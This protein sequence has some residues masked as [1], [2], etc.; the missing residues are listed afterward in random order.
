MDFYKRCSIILQRCWEFKGSYHGVRW[1]IFQ[2]LKLL[3]KY[4][5]TFSAEKMSCHKLV[6]HCTLNFR[7][8]FLTTVHYTSKHS[9]LNELLKIWW[10]L[11]DVK[12]KLML[13]GNFP[14]SSAAFPIQILSLWRFCNTKQKKRFLLFSHIH[15]NY[16]LIQSAY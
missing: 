15:M 6:N 9:E 13:K 4:F 3:I 14:F 1:K 8:F 16:K 5:N 12:G 11:I 2:S 7:G 10:K